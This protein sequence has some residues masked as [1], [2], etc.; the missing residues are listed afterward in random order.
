MNRTL[1][2]FLY[3][4]LTGFA[5]YWTSNLLLW[6]PWS[7]SAS[8]GITLM[9]TLAPLLWVYAVYK[10]L[11]KFPGQQ[12]FAA[13]FFIAIIFLFV[14]GLLDYLFF[15]LYRGAMEELYK[16]TTFYGYAFLLVLPFLEVLVVPKRLKR[17]RRPL[18]LRNFL[19]MA[20][21]GLITL[22][23]LLVIIYFDV[24]I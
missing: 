14:A 3:T 18:I 2:W 4:F 16:P 15:G 5:F 12:F 21:L 1:K 20:L 9:L 23:L 22:G 7:I 11:L 10:C 24:R 17:N 6:F 13:G 19:R 8:L